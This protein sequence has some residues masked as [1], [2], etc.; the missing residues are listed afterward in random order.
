[1]ISGWLETICKEKIEK[2]VIPEV[3]MEGVN[4]SVARS[5]HQ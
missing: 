3:L 5:L 2:W 1:V 4:T